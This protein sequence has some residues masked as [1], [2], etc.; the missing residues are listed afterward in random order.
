MTQRAVKK[1][2]ILNAPSGEV[3]KLL[4]DPDCIKKFLFD[5]EVKTS[6]KKDT[7][8]EFRGNW[9]GRDF[10]GKGRIVE[11]TPNALLEY[12]YFSN[13]SGLEDSDENYCHVIYKLRENN[14]QTVLSVT[15]TNL[16]S[17]DAEEQAEEYWEMV[18]ERIKKISDSRFSILDS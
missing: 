8:I 3:W 15:Q 12:T 13:L 17:K 16:A 10:H 7:P 14:G 1:S 11:N 9:K 4:T 5:A 6:W 2:V 18:L